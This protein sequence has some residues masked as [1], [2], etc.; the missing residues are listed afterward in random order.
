MSEKKGETEV[1]RQVKE[2]REKERK[3]RRDIATTGEKERER[4]RG[5]S[6]K[7]H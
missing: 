4:K 3:G 1:G 7:I 6:V 2:K 5:H